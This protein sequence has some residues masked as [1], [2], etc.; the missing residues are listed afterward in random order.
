MAALKIS[1]L[2]KSFGHS[3]V[4]RDVTL[5]IASGDLVAILGASGS[6]KTT[7]LRL[8]AGFERAESGDIE[9]DDEV[10]ASGTVFKRPEQRGIGYVAQEGALF[11]HLSVAD[12]ITFGLSRTAKV[13]IPGH[14]LL[15]LVDL[16]VTYA[17]RGPQALSGGEQQRVAL[18]R[19]LAPNPKLVLLDEPFSA[20]DA[21]LRAETREAV[22]L[23][24]RAAGA[25]AILV[26]H[27]Q[28][29]A[30]SMGSRVG[31]LQQG[32]LTQMSRPEDLYRHPQTAG[33]A[34]FIGDAVFVPGIARYGKIDCVLGALSASD[35]GLDGPVEVMIRPEQIKLFGEPS[36]DATKARVG[37]VVFHGHD[38]IVKLHLQNPS[39]A[40]DITARVF[41]QILPK[42]GAAV[43]FKVEGE[44]VAYPTL[45]AT[46]PPPAVSA[47]NADTPHHDSNAL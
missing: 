1:H 14:E 13:Q 10:I 17:D 21:G 8:I 29:E 39:L 24:I 3:L 30:L 46:M 35:R 25:T 19:A 33:I 26:T 22:A 34:N 23:A 41:S 18:A 4:L 5:Q 2:T 27:D 28:S 42:S 36:V 40:T 6:G 20:L 9:I 47:L 11:P 7:L 43:W 15:T 16:P 38:A 37:T 45:S 12:N 44:V 32:I 31:V